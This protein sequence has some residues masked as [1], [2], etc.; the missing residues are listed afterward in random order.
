MTYRHKFIFLIKTYHDDLKRIEILTKSISEHNKENIPVFISVPNEDYQLFNKLISN[1]NDTNINLIKDEELCNELITE[2][3]NNF[4][5]GYINQQLV[6]MTFWKSKIAE[7]YLCLDSDIYF[8]KDFFISDFMY[9]QNTPFSVL[10]Q[11]KDLSLDPSYKGYY[12]DRTQKI[13]SIFESIGVK[14]K[15][16]RT[17]HGNTVISSEVLKEFSSLYLKSKPFHTI[18]INES[19]EFSWYNAWL[20]KNNLINYKACESFF[21]VFHTKDQYFNC[22][23]YNSEADISREYLGICLNSN[24][25]DKLKVYKYGFLPKN[26]RFYFKVELFLIKLISILRKI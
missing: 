11:D 3:I 8:T 16:I 7:F 2:Q 5:I 19:F 14:G 1:S 22:L 6:K 26:R 9:D 15:N 20:Q 18:L 12:H 4:S 23:K 24:W 25:A 10:V 21:K 13:Q 17:C